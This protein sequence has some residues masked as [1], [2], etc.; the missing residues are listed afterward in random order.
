MATFAQ[1]VFSAM[2]GMPSSQDI[3]GWITQLLQQQGPQARLLQ[4]QQ[5]QMAD[6]INQTPVADTLAATPNIDALAMGR[7]LEAGMRPPP[8]APRVNN[9]TDPNAVDVPPARNNPTNP[10]AFDAPA[11][12]ALPQRAEVPP[13]TTGTVTREGPQIG[14]D[15]QALIAAN[16][17]TPFRP[18][19]MAPRVQRATEGGLRQPGVADYA[20][21]FFGGL[22]GGPGILG[23]RGLVAQT[24][25]R[26]ATYDALIQKGATPELARAITT[27]SQLFAPVLPSLFAPRTSIVNNRLVD[28]TTGRL[29]ADFSDQFRP[30]QEGTVGVLN[31]A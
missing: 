26:N 24:E 13:F 4:P 27:N 19:P 2:P 9:P 17:N 16:E 25:A 29:I 20:N 3:L 21:A 8:M 28:T 7:R 12:D 18:P 22:N 11:A 1:D 14:P 15:M 5:S 30:L 31:Q 23:Q 10:Y 6:V